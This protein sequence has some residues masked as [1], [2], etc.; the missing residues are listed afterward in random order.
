M[1]DFGKEKPRQRSTPEVQ[2]V[3]VCDP[4]KES[5]DYVDWSKNGVR[6][7]MEGL[8]RSLVGEKA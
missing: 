5:T 3:A 8:S 2:I 6:D 4:N 1:E 7:G